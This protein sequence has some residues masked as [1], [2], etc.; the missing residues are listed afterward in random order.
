MI[1]RKLGWT[2]DFRGTAMALLLAGLAC[3]GATHPAMAQAGAGGNAAE[4]WRKS[5]P[6]LRLKSDTN[7][8]GLLTEAEFTQLN[9][10]FG[11]S[12]L[13]P[14]EVNLA[15]LRLAQLQPAMTLVEEAAAQRRCD[16]ELDRSKGFE[17]EL[18]QLSTMRHAARLLALQGDLQRGDGDMKG[19]ADAQA[20]MA[21]IATQPGQEDVLIG[22]LVGQA[23][24]SLSMG[25]VRD[26]ISDGEVSPS[27]AKE[28]LESL[29][30][31]HGDDPFHFN[32]GP[33]SEYEALQATLQTYARKGKLAA[34]LFGMLGDPKL[35]ESARRMK[36]ADLLA[37]LPQVKGAY[38]QMSAAMREKDPAR[39][40][41]MI[42][43]AMASVENLPPPANMFAQLMPALDRVMDNRA[44]FTAELADLERTLKEIS[45]DPAAQAK[46]TDPAVLWS[47]VAAQVCALP[48]ESQTAVEILRAQ[49]V[50][51]AGD[52]TPTAIACLKGCDQTI[53]PLMRVA[54]AGERRNLDF[55][56][57]RGSR[58]RPPLST[59]GGMRGAARLAAA[60]TQL[61][62]TDQAI[63]H[64]DLAFA[65]VAAL[66]SDPSQASSVTSMMAAR[67]LVPAVAA[68]AQR[69][70]LTPERRT[71]LEAAVNRIER[72]DAFGFR[73]ALAAE[74]AWLLDALAPIEPADQAKRQ[75]DIARRT[76]EWILA[77]RVEL[78]DE[79]QLAIPN[80]GAMEDMAD[81]FPPERLEKAKAAHEAI[82][83]RMKALQGIGADDANA[84]RPTLASLPVEPLRDTAVDA[85]EAQAVLS[86][87][88]AALRPA[89][90]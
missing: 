82:A 66:A 23:I 9:E 33:M 58:A 22:S 24:G 19:F 40:K 38:E 90:R 80:A 54:A 16:F 2:R 41:A 7:P 67:D 43:K 88:D 73:A 85:Q 63:A 25:R 62:D 53:F 6:L 34:E 5:D 15:R 57:V 48:D 89:G 4:A 50:E 81:L 35:A 39:A 55:M 32:A 11:R 26:A 44:K 13:S 42:A 51:H 31:M 17:L 37:S 77:A 1:R 49:G 61:L 56:K 75:K 20:A 30:P 72:R 28:L 47:R 46:Y 84:K 59:L 70:D 12:N 36:A 78:S 52:F 71:A 27:Q 65:A 60:R 69:P 68:I 79:V 76:P 14:E 45:E 3:L 29:A 8:D 10:L 87:L 64:L 18:P 86:A 21:R 83:E 74:R